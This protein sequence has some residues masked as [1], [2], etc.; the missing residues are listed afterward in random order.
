[1]DYR[2]EQ[3]GAIKN[4]PEKISRLTY[5]NAATAVNNTVRVALDIV[6]GP[7]P[8]GESGLYQAIKQKRATIRNPESSISAR[9]WL[10]DLVENKTAAHKIKPHDSVSHMTAGVFKAALKF[11]YQGRIQFARVVKH[12]GTKGKHSWAAGFEWIET[13]LPPMVQQAVEAAL[14][15]EAWTGGPTVYTNNKT[16]TPLVY[17][18][19]SK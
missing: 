17:N 16:P 6:R 9:H 14:R 18:P 1:M 19:L 8:K 13:S 10:L 3:S 7:I 5:K 12:P 4:P 15:G 2:V 11:P